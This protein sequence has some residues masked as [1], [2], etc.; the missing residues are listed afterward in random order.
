MEISPEVQQPTLFHRRYK[1][2]FMEENETNIC[3]QDWPPMALLGSS[4]T[5]L[6]THVHTHAHTNTHA[7]T[8][9]HHTA[10]SLSHDSLSST[11]RATCSFNQENE[12][13]S[14]ITPRAFLVFSLLLGIPPPH[15]SIFTENAS[16]HFVKPLPFLRSSVSTA[17]S[18]LL[19]LPV[20]SF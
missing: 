20:F 18:L 16:A 1:V 13:S 17:P 14:A 3:F 11:L 6:P 10:V 7:H 12:L 5:T 8:C 2:R 15:H 4:V 19:R 9:S